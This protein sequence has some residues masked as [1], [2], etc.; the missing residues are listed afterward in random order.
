MADAPARRKALVLGATG[1]LGMAFQEAVRQGEGKGLA[2]Q[3][4][5][6]DRRQC[7]LA[8]P[9]AV[10]AALL[11][12]QPDLIFN[13]AAYTAVDQAE[14]EPELAARVNA[15]SVR[16][17]ARYAGDRQVPIV[18]FSTDYVF[19]GSSNRPYTEADR[20][21][22]VSVYGRTKLAGEKAVQS[23]SERHLVIR[24]SWVYGRHGGNFM[25]TMLRLAR[26][27]ESLRVVADQWGV[28]TSALSLAQQSL[29]ACALAWAEPRGTKWGLYHLTGRGETHWH[30]YA[31]HVLARAAQ[32]GVP[33]RVSAEQ[34][35]AIASHEFPTPAPRPSN[36]RLDC[37]RWANAFAWSGPDWRQ[38]VDGVLLEVLT[39]Q[40]VL[41]PAMRDK[42]TSER[43]A[44]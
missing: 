36:S 8:Q 15:D 26:E 38:E 7:D 10:T 6:A 42:I 40:G 20:P 13:A 23:L 17:L 2:D 1:Q 22:P 24:T 35:V 28:P 31:C 3:W 19:D 5:W 30:G 16:A 39:D 41:T 25:K 33:L 11:G 34:V 14:S 29:R 43:S 44:Q 9:D 37:T 4:I 21:S 12:W 32:W 27:R 18:H